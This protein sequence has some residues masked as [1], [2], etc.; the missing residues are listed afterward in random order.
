MYAFGPPGWSHDGSRKTV[1][2]IQREMN[3]LNFQAQDEM[4]VEL[5][6]HE[7]EVVG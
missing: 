3:S 5:Y 2:E 7:A 1:R 4:P 6:K